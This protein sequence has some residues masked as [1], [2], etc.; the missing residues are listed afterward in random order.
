MLWC[1][2]AA[3]GE[4]AEFDTD[5]LETF[6]SNL[7]TNVV[8]LGKGR[9]PLCRLFDIGLIGRVNWINMWAGF[10]SGDCY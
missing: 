5:P 6:P 8:L 10:V 4:E 7:N 9:L 2:V 1:C 3:P